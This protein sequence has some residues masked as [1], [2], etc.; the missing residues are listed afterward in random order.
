MLM[1]SRHSFAETVKTD[2][3]YGYL[4]QNL[5]ILRN[6]LLYFLPTKSHVFS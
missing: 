3:H 1:F 5:N 2:S 4:R 6:L